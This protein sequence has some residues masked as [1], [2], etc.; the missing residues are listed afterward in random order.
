MRF[1]HLKQTREAQ[2]GMTFSSAPP[3]HHHTSVSGSAH[4][5]WIILFGEHP[6]PDVV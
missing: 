1:G 2:F 4:W 5:R 6:R 3:R